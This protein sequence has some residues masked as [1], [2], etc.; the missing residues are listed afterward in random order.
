MSNTARTQRI[1]AR[2]AGVLFLWLIVSAIGG[3]FI[4]SGIAGDGT[5]AEIAKR[6]S[7]SEHLYRAGLSLEVI[8]A[9]SAVVFAFALYVTVKPVN[10]LLAMLAMVFYLQD[11]FLASVSRMCGFVRLHLY[12]SSQIV[13]SDT[14]L[15]ET[16]ADL[17]RSMGRITENIGGISFGIAMVLFF[18][19]FFKSRYIPRI[20]SAFGLLVSAVWTGLYFAILVFPEQRAPVLSIGNPLVLVADITTAFWLIL[21]AV[22]NPEYSTIVELL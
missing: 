15:L 11:A 14:A 17:A 7:A 1:Y 4:V 13:P 22:K 18:Y 8:E 5:F 21:F 6:I 10:T 19:L 12:T 2:V 16:L 3:D 20:L 9:C